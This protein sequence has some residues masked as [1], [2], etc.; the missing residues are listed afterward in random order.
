MRCCDFFV[1]VGFVFILVFL[2]VLCLVCSNHFCVCGVGLCGW[3][4]FNVWLCCFVV[5]VCLLLRVWFCL[6]LFV[7]ALCCLLVVLFKCGLLCSVT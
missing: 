2:I 5:C 6:G 4:V 1:S 7:F 3:F